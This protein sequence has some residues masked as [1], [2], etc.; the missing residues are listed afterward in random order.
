MLEVNPRAS[1]D[2][3]VRLEG[4]RRARW[5]RSRRRC[6]V[7]QSLREQ[8]FT[9]E[10][11]P[12]ARERQGGRVPVHQV[13][14]RGHR[15]RPRDEVDRRGDGHRRH[16]RRARSR[17][18]RSRAARSCR[19]RAACS[20]RCRRCTTTRVVPIARRLARAGFTLLA[21]PGPATP[22]RAAGLDVD[23]PEQGAGR[24][25]RTS[26]TRMRRGD[27]ALVVNTPVGRRVVPRLVP[28]PAHRARVPA[29]RTSRRS[30]R[31]SPPSRA[32]RPS[33]AAR[34]MV[35]PLQEHYR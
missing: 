4:H 20:S 35:R 19:R 33:R 9:R 30:R 17:R 29:C 2:R 28:D 21:T 27:V 1:R 18:R 24:A 3:A 32:S 5:P 6:M 14:G 26:W 11:V 7:G 16:V 34:S 8:G 13:P 10:I 22:L 12:R 23:D 25:R 15:A 31:R